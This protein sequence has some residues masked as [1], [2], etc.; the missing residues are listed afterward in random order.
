MSLAVAQ[1]FAGAGLRI[2]DRIRIS[3]GKFM[4]ITTRKK[5][6]NMCMLVIIRW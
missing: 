2:L 6:K 4:L 5:S 1:L 3:L